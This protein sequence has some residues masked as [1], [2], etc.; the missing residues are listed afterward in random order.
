MTLGIAIVVF[1]VAAALLVRVG[2][3]LARSGDELAEQT[4]LG[5]VFVGTLLVAFATSLPEVATDVTATVAGAPDLAVADLFGSS[6]ANMAILAIIDLRYRGRVWPSVELGHAR[7]AAL[8]IVLTSIA[9][10][11]IVRPPSVSIGWVGIDTI[12]IAGCYVAAMAWLRRTPV[13]GRAE[14]PSRLLLEQPVG[15]ATVESDPPRRPAAARFGLAAL[16]ILATAPLVALSAK[17]IAEQ[18]GVGEMAVGSTL[19]AISTSMPELVVALAAV[20]I[21]AHDL[22]VGNLFGSNVANMSVLLVLD[23]VH[24]D[25]PILAAVDPSQVTAAMGAVLLMALGL[26]A[27]VGGTETRIR[28]LEPD[29]VLVLAVYVGVLVAVASGG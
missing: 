4:G 21:G 16:G 14:R 28:R 22:A 23:L 24:T 17:E 18:T 27:I 19:V 1:V 26:A 10:L 12:A 15:L 5:A 20:R 6:M 7:V 8:A 2:S 29:A 25:G 3:S 11:G 9:V 13:A